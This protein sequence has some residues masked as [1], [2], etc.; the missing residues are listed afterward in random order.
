MGYCKP[1]YG[2]EDLNKEILAIDEEINGH[3]IAVNELA[4]KREIY[5]KKLKKE[6]KAPNNPENKD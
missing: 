3:L 4:I 5:V 2:I 6:V 1:Y